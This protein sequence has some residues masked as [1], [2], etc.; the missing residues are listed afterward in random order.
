M[1][2]DTFRALPP[3]PQTLEPS[4]RVVI[5]VPAFEPHAAHLEAALDSLLAQTY[6]SYAVIVVDDSRDDRVERAV[7][8]RDEH[9]TR[10]QHVRNDVRLGLVGNTRRAF[11][12]ATEAYPDA[13]LFAWGSDHDVWDRRWLAELVA[14]LDAH[15]RAVLAWPHVEV[16][17][18][19]GV[20]PSHRRFDTT[21]IDEPRIRLAA[22][23]RH[24]RAGLLIYGL[25][26]VGA[27]HRAGPFPNTL[28]P[29]RLLLARL[30]LLGQFVQVQQ[31]LWQ[32][33]RLARSSLERQREMLFQPRPPRSARL[34]PDLVHA[35]LLAWWLVARGGARPGVGRVA[36]VRTS[37]RYAR[38][39]RERRRSRPEDDL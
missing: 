39:L 7:R 36:G 38:L 28:T 35:A 22:A 33:R 18:E 13:E 21:A 10:L 23:V 29:D 5:G 2:S 25:C 20:R 34:P 17:G 16:L 37:V 27:L 30:A 24:M 32:R 11:D 12:L 26:R 31:P 6:R 15:P 3:R 8:A 4:P 9:G 19:D 1:G 14:A